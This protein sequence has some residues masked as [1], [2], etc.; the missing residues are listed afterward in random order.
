M[1][2]YVVWATVLLASAAPL[3]AGVPQN[4]GPYNATFLAGGIGIERDLDSADSL[5][6][7]G[8]AYTISA[9]VRPSLAQR[10]V[11][12]S[13]I[14][15]PNGACRCLGLRNGRLVFSD[16]RATVIGAAVPLNG[17]THVAA[18]FDGSQVSLYVNGKET[19]RSVIPSRAVAPRIGIA[20]MVDGQEH[21][22]GTLV[23]ATVQ[24][25]AFSP[26][27]VAALYGNRPQFELVQIWKVG[28]GWEWQKTANTGY[29]RQQD[30]WT[31]PQSKVAYSAPVAKP[32]PSLPPLEPEGDGR[33]LINGWQLAAAPD[34]RTGG[35][36]LS[37]PGNHSGR[38]FAAT[39]PGT[40]LTT[41]VDRGVY[42]DPYYGLNNLRIPESLARQNYWY[43]TSFNVPAESAGKSS[44]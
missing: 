2:H 5:T 12:L 14:G 21:F 16:G 20:P 7:A 10:E 43:R 35:A 11:T 1:R 44:T 38:W 17:W 26:A 9:W 23:G 8:A 13:S 27:E 33:W 34:G 40:V 32:V 4:G 42:P 6:R 29:W 31:L 3:C 36:E 15:D 30:P 19:G 24:D 28:Q 41:L 25:R 18:V 22:G 39:V 37:R